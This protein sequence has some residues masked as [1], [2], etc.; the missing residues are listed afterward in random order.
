MGFLNSL[1]V[2]IK[3][4]NK[5]LKSALADS[6]KKMTNFGATVKKIGGYIAAAF[7]VRAIVNFTKEAVQLAAEAEGIKAAFERIGNPKLL[8]D[9]K[10]ATKGTV[11]ELELMRR[12]VMASNFQLPM[13]QLASL[14]EFATKRAQET[15]QSVD[16]LVQSIV[17][18]IGR[19]SPLILDNLG[20]SAVRLREELKGAG[21]ELTTVADVAGAVG[22]IAA[23]EMQKA[24]G[25]I[26]T[27]GVKIEQIKAKWQEVKLS[28]GENILASES[29]KTSLNE[30][31]IFFDLMGDK[32]L[33]FGEKMKIVF[34]KDYLEYQE[35]SQAF[36]D[37]FKDYDLESLLT[38]MDTLSKRTD[39]ESK[40]LMELAL[41]REEE[42]ALMDRKD[43]AAI[44]EIKTMESIDKEINTLRENL[45]KTSTAR[46]DVITEIYAHIRALEAEKAAVEALNAERDKSPQI[47]AVSGGM[48]TTA[49]VRTI[50][51]PVDV[52]RPLSELISTLAPMGE[53]AG[54]AFMNGMD[55]YMNEAVFM[56]DN[57]TGTLQS[58]FMDMADVVT[59][60][61][62]QIF[63][64]IGSGN[65]EG[66]FNN[67]LGGMGSFIANIG[68]MLVAYGAAML[69]FSILSKSPDP[70]SATAAIGAGLAAIAI[71]SLIKGA[72]SKGVQALGGGGGGGGSY[73]SASK[74]IQTQTMT[75]QVEGILKGSDI[76]ISNRRAVALQGGQT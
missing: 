16:Y 53:Q 72:A 60:S 31:V 7:G 22:K 43:K 2:R 48:V 37:T 27:T 62:E 19:K 68:K 24:G 13:N 8:D 58:A 20:I 73:S 35:R 64:G 50:E 28:F 57:W 70:I 12:A 32:A 75:I 34:K 36:A 26:E 76:L 25:I 55:S 14:L 67:I 29:L 23:E 18:G 66:V 63:E 38:A 54:A 15:G 39:E 65:L 45:A 5:D 10:R 11:S 61:V 59:N 56:V 21:V 33:T 1:I 47:K 40:K 52:V 6:N 17:L 71:G 4:D 49:N 9:L 51:P 46:T 44:V 69:A 42:L 30:W 3:G 41:A 74:G